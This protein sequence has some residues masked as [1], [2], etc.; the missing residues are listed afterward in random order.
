MLTMI[1][2]RIFYTYAVLYAVI[3]S[4]R[5][6]KQ[7]ACVRDVVLCLLETVTVFVDLYEIYWI[8]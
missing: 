1:F 3:Y 8:L 7:I 4:L 5:A 6:I 2:T